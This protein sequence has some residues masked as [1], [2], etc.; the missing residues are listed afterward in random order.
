[1]FETCVNIGGISLFVKSIAF[2]IR[3]TA[4]KKSRN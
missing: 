1:L 3:A 2:W 4:L